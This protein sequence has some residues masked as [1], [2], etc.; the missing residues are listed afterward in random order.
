MYQSVF[1]IADEK[2]ECIIATEVI[3]F[4]HQ[5]SIIQFRF[6]QMSFTAETATKCFLFLQ[7]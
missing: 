7:V 5:F 4:F 2:N 1:V 3:F 6:F